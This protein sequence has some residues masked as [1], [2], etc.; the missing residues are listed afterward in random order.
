M[1]KRATLF[2][3]FTRGK[4]LVIE[5]PS[6]ASVEVWVQKISPD[7]HD[8]SLR[9]ANAARAKVTLEMREEGHEERLVVLGDVRTLDRDTLIDILISEDRAQAAM[10]IEAQLELAE[11]SEWGKDGYLEGLRDLW[12]ERMYTQWQED[13]NDPEASRVLAEMRRFTAEVNEGL[14]KVVRDLRIGYEDYELE[15]LR[16][17]ALERLMEQRAGEIWIG[18]FE[19]SRLYFA[20]REPDNHR[21]YYFSDAGFDGLFALA[22]EVIHQLMTAYADLAVDALQG[23]DLPRTDGSSPSSEPPPV[24]ETPASSSLTASTA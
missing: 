11:G 12:A 3:L 2:D 8:K 14:D 22:D 6:G 9:R 5:D 10:S 1:P 7:E 13:E 24:E 23:K 17:R 16:E 19:R 20:I 18:E 15:V 4:P 21:A